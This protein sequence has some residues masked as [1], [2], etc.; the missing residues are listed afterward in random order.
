MKVLISI[1]LNHIHWVW[2]SS[3]TLDW[4]NPIYQGGGGIPFLQY[5]DRRAI[6][7]WRSTRNRFID[8][9]RGLVV[10]MIGPTWCYYFCEPVEF[11]ADWSDALNLK[12]LVC[13]QDVQINFE[14]N[15]NAL[16]GDEVET[17]GHRY[18]LNKDAQKDYIFIL[19]LSAFIVKP[20]DVHLG[21]T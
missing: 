5:E 15:A 14:L 8:A 13:Q 4:K 10:S 20:E 2:V 18:W 7:H 12:L 16:R 17:H 11:T 19:N 3:Q 6:Q 21:Q 1:R 9:I